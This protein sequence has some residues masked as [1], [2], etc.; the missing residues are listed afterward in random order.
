MNPA[1]SWLRR[2]AMVT[3]YAA[4]LATLTA[5][6]PVVIVA[7]GV[8]DL[9]L[10]KPWTIVRTLAF[11]FWYLLCELVGVAASVA[12]WL[13]SGVWAGADRER[14]LVW[15]YALQRAWGQALGRG[16]FR[17]FGVTVEVEDDGCDFGRRPLLL[18]VRHASTAD[19]ILALLLVTVPHR[20]RL[21]YV[22]KR[23]L[24]WDPCLDIVGNRLPNV[25]V[26][27]DFAHTGE[28]A[29]AIAELGRGLTAGEGVLIYPEG[30]RFSEAKKR[31]IVTRFRE[32]GRER[33]AAEAEALRS[34]LP[35]R[36]A[37]P[38][39][40]LESARG[41]DAVFC[42]HTGLEGSASFDR[43]FNGGLVGAVVR[44]RFRHVPAERIPATSEERRRWL[45]DEWRRVDAFVSEA[46][47]E[48]DRRA[49][50]A[51]REPRR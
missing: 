47:A 43:F 29:E 16:A 3:L 13:A 18:F 45:L 10:A 9:A 34:V 12:I 27:R 49:V 42:A 36:S 32:A 28:D 20:I 25:F 7:A 4:A 22:L 14:F 46:T 19:T 51:T 31:R 5:T 26:R 38:L 39:A 50:A 6:F 33:E 30:T 8:L 40:L 15:N 21:R 48:R 24:L 2:I 23:Q 17:I 35:P 1:A 11:F 44:V 41:A 37:G